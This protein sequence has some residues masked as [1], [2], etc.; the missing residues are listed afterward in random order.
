MLIWAAERE[1]TFKPIGHLLLQPASATVREHQLNTGGLILLH[2]SKILLLMLRILGGSSHFLGV[3]LLNPGQHVKRIYCRRSG[4][5]FQTSKVLYF[6]HFQIL[7]FF[8]Y[9]CYTIEQRFQ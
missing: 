7:I 2:C 8:F 4:K 1:I 3:F 5:L 9:P 6:T